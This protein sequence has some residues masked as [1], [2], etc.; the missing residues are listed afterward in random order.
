MT[1]PTGESQSAQLTAAG[2]AKCDES[3]GGDESEPV[4]QG[5]SPRKSE[6]AGESWS[7]KSVKRL[8]TGREGVRHSVVQK[9]TE[10]QGKHI[11]ILTFWMQF[12]TP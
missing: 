6:A 2:K 8:T 10:L 5:R 9:A 11:F 1:R 4:K 3:V 7:S 12:Q